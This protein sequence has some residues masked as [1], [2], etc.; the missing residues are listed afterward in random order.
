MN[1][2]EIIIL[3]IYIYKRDFI[4]SNPNPVS[5]KMSLFKLADYIIIS[6]I[7]TQTIRVVFKHFQYK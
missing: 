7:R 3:S 6:S 5:C 2:L 1:E 4:I